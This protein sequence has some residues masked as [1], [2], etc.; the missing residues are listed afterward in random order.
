MTLKETDLTIR[1]NP[2]LVSKRARESCSELGRKISIFGKLIRDIIYYPLYRFLDTKRVE[3]K[4]SQKLENEEEY[5][6][7]FWTGKEPKDLN[8][9]CADIIRQMYVVYDQPVIVLAENGK[10]ITSVCRVIESKDC[11]KEGIFNAFLIPG[12]LST[13]NNNLFAFYDF[14]VAHSKQEK[15]SHARFFIFGYYEMSIE[16]ESSQSSATYKPPTLEASGEVLKRTLEALQEEFGKFN[17][18]FAHSAGCIT[19]ASLLKRSGSE[20]LP[21]MLHF[22]RGPSSLYEVS[23]HYWFGGL[24]YAIAKRNGLVIHVDQEIKNFFNR[25]SKEDSINLQKCTCMVTGVEEDFVYPGQAGLATSNC[26]DD[27]QIKIQLTKWVFNPPEQINHS[28][29]HHNWRLVCFNKS[30]MTSSKGSVEML[31]EENLAQAILRL[32]QSKSSVK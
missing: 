15:G 24:L 25:C 3:N 32:A 1:R 7:R 14:L 9:E 22:D 21:T 6:N 30:Y 31:P 29:A 16:I 2:P 12:S 13:L 10:K 5:Y 28:R 11:P 19:L 4:I 17:L 23:R 27:F 18:V 26:L 8:L 20:L